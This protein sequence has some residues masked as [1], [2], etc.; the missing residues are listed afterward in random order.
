MWVIVPLAGA[1][2]AVCVCGRV[3]V[4]QARVVPVVWASE[5]FFPQ[6]CDRGGSEHA[7]WSTARGGA[8]L[9]FSQAHDRGDS[10]GCIRARHPSGPLGAS[11][12]L[13]KKS[14]LASLVF[15]IQ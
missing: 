8:S 2:A 7:R 1:A 9:F 13:K 12:S 6:A 3:K 5:P 11:P 15:F 4:G 14:K 10:G